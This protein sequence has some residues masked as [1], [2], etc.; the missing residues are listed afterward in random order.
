ML[1]PSLPLLEPFSSS[2][3]P[4]HLRE[5]PSRRRPR[6][7]RLGSLSGIH[8][9]SF[10]S[11]KGLF[12]LFPPLREVVICVKLCNALEI[13]PPVFCFFS[14]LIPSFTPSLTCKKQRLHSSIAP[15]DLLPPDVCYDDLSFL[16]HSTRSLVRRALSGASFMP[17][18]R[19]PPMRSNLS[20]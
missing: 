3:V 11:W 15:R 1:L 18:Y 19:A 4:C 12:P 2:L 5:K 16:R 17:G 14:L 6:A 8:N 20:L 9:T 10:P 7:S 13:F